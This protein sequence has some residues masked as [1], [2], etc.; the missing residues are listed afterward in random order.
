MKILSYVAVYFMGK[1]TLLLLSQCLSDFCSREKP[2]YIK[3]DP[4][5]PSTLG[6]NYHIREVL[7]TRGRNYYT[8]CQ[9]QTP[10]A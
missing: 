1:E 7:E 5:L 2:A 10:L 6:K 8:K 4:P 3:T 9:V